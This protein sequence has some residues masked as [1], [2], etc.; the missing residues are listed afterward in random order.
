MACLYELVHLA[1]RVT[2]YEEGLP[3]LERTEKQFLRSFVRIPVVQALCFTTKDER[4]GYQLMDLIEQFGDRFYPKGSLEEKKIELNPWKVIWEVNS[5]SD[6]YMKRVV[7][8]DLLSRGT[9][10]EQLEEIWHQCLEACGGNVK[11]IFDA[12][13]KTKGNV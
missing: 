5:P 7:L 6:E 12:A 9:S 8:L 13:G 2:S 3:I 10:D 11:A 1:S 4:Y